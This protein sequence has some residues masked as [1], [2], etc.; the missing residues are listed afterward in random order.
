MLRSGHSCHHTS[1]GSAC[2]CVCTRAHSWLWRTC[3]CM[4]GCC[5]R[6]F[7]SFAESA[8]TAADADAASA[9]CKRRESPDCGELQN[10]GGGRTFLTRFSLDSSCNVLVPSRT[11][12]KITAYPSAL[13]A[14]SSA[15]LGNR[16]LWCGRFFGKLLNLASVL[17][18]G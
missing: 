1:D 3:T 14:I 18:N 7:C 17:A 6:A 8:G 9:W 4:A 10:M 11:G 5:R 16:A 13:C 12:C 15:R 2:G